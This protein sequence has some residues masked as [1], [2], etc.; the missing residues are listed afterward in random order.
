MVAVTTRS[1]LKS[2]VWLTLGAFAIGTEGFMI[3]GLLPAL[4]R[5]LNVGLLAAGHL[6]TAFSLTYAIGAPVMAVL[7]AGLERRRLVAVTMGGFALANLL[8]ALAPGYVGLLGA[9]L[10]LAL[11]AASFMPAASGYAA[12]LGGPERRGRALSIVTN[13]LT[14]AIIAGVPLGVLMGDRFGWRAPFLGVAGLAALSLLGILARLPRQSPGATAG[15]VERLALA[16]RRDMLA[17]LATSVL[18]VAATFT[19]YT[20]IG[21]FLAGV[22]GLG[23]QGLALVLLGF[24]LASALGTRLGGSAADRL[25]ARS[26][27]IVGGG[28]ALLA[29]VALSLGATL[30]P[31]QAMRVLLPAILLWGLASWGLMPAQQARLVALAPSL[32]SVSL[33]LNSSA[34]YL[35]SAMGAAVGAL[36]IAD[37]AIDRLG[38]VATG[39]STAALV[40]VLASG[41][42]TSDQA[43]SARTA[44]PGLHGGDRPAT[45][46][47]RRHGLSSNL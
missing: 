5:D 26:T 4:A 42:T 47:P 22:A 16:K 30:G 11:S 7:T 32:A 40:A 43:L 39:F 29:Y 23:A 46:R 45:S 8:A 25:S 21:V 15:L 19:V 3:A 28:L 14:L 6:V 35:G 31:Q 13:G 24:G 38:W 18:T 10:L 41:S 33:S 12:T 34:I 36:V 1:S 17:V 9:R 37:G 2:L 27:V 20:Y 44:V